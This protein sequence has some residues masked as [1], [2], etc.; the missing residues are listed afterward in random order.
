MS[1]VSEI[2]VV[3]SEAVVSISDGSTYFGL[4]VGPRRLLQLR[5]TLVVNLLPENGKLGTIAQKK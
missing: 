5:V 4:V 3:K 1:L 2:P